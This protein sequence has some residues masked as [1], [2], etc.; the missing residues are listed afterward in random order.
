MGG[1]EITMA[2]LQANMQMIIGCKHVLLMALNK[3][4]SPI[5]ATS[6][7]KSLI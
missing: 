3:F 6:I 2:A 7:A 4:S 1:L 5:F